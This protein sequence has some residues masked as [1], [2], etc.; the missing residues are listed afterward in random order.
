MHHNTLSRISA[1]LVETVLATITDVDDLDDLGYQTVIEQI[2][3]AQLRLEV[4]RTSKDEARHVD[5]V[6]RDEVLDRKLGDLA[7]VVVSLLVTQTGETQRGLT[8]TAVLLREIDREFVDDFARV[9]GEGSEQGTVTVHDDEAETGVRFEQFG[10]RFGM[11]LVVTK[12]QRSWK[13]SK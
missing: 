8:T 1:N 13:V 6:G 11:E 5:P 12:V 3:L 9:A 4:G 10:E 2:T 7:N